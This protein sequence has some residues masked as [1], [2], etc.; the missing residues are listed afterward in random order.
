[1]INKIS[2]KKRTPITKKEF[3]REVLKRPYT[4]IN[5]NISFNIINSSIRGP[6]SIS[7]KNVTFQKEIKIINLLCLE[8]ITFDN[9]S[10]EGDVLISSLKLWESV[11]SI[12]IYNCR[13]NSNL[14]F[15][16][17]ELKKELIIK[18][19]HLES[20]KI[21]ELNLE[22]DLILQNIKINKELLL[23]NITFHSSLILSNLQVKGYTK[24][25]NIINFKIKTIHSILKIEDCTFFDFTHLRELHYKGTIKLNNNK[26]IRLSEISFTSIYCK[27]LMIER[28]TALEGIDIDF[29]GMTIEAFRLIAGTQ[30]KGKLSLS[31]GKANHFDMT[32][33]NEN[34]YLKIVSF[35][36]SSLIF[37]N[38][39]NLKSISLV[40]CNL[41]S[42]RNKFNRFILSNCLLGNLS[43]Y[44]TN[45]SDFDYV[46]IINS[47]LNEVSLYNSTI[48][49]PNTITRFDNKE[50]RHIFQQLKHANNSQS[51][52]IQA[53][54]FKAYEMKSYFY[55]LIYEGKILSEDGLIML[56]SWTNGFGLKWLRP[57]VISIIWTL[58][59][60]VFIVLS[61]KTSSNNWLLINQNWQAFWQLF[62]PT[63]RLDSLFQDYPNNLTATSYF[64]DFLHRL[65]YAFIIYQVISAFRKFY[66]S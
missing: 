9:C 47:S 2:K 1:M 14:Q 56:L 3:R 21:N 27:Y 19:S 54:E 45:F 17:N 26:F 55:N 32:G 15:T 43:L 44:N 65:G 38:V 8:C 10:F 22:N 52:R 29:S 60:Y 6:K 20:L 36:F 12:E 28:I 66:K 51:D 34:L 48:F 13:F 5:K 59:F 37:N 42:N 62:N 49:N 7:F 50:S 64:L 57:I 39:N 23:E 53:L 33:Y 40:G 4:I 16:N 58:T 11:T 24:F 31:N 41:I 35:S 63:H 46:K 61:L 30:T 25:N 18:D